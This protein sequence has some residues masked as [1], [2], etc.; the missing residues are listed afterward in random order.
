MATVSVRKGGDTVTAAK[1]AVHVSCADAD[2]NDD[3]AY[4]NTLYPASPAVTYY[5]SAEKSGIDSLVSHVFTPNGGAHV[6]DNVVFPDDGTWT[7]HLRKTA[8]DSS[9]ANVQQIVAAAS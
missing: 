5:F 1:T 8:D 7:I 4:D 9:V 3:T 2:S 6:W